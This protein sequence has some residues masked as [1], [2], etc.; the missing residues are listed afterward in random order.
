MNSLGLLQVI[1]RYV[2]AEVAQ[3][4]S[5]RPARL[6]TVNPAHTTGRPRLTFDGESTLSGKAYPYLSPYVPAAGDRVLLLPVGASYVVAGK[7]L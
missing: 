1:A 4:S 3:S 2:R 6:A 5:S 7:V